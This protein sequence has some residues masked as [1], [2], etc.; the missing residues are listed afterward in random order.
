MRGA[1]AVKDFEN[2]VALHLRYVFDP[3]RIHAGRGEIFTPVRVILCRM[4]PSP[5]PMQRFQDP[6]LVDLGIGFLQRLRFTKGGLYD[7]SRAIMRET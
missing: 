4:T 7:P 2:S 6:S 5:F 3:D 1:H